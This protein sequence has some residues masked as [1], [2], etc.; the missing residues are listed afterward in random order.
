MRDSG[1]LFAAEVMAAAHA[2]EAISHSSIIDEVATYDARS[3][4]I[5]LLFI[6]P[7]PCDVY[8][9]LLDDF[10]Y[11]TTSALSPLRIMPIATRVL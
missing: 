9:A 8:Q 3:T 4:A 1:T 5:A 10:E 2:V 6:A 7:A 11:F